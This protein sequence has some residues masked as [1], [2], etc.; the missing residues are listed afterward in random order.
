MSS[1]IT[2]LAPGATVTLELTGISCAL[3]FVLSV[4]L[5]IGTNSRVRAVG[6]ACRRYV[7]VFRSVPLLAIL[8]LLFFGLPTVSP[9]LA[10]SALWCSVIGIAVSEAAF[11]AEIYAGAIRSVSRAQWD[12]AASIGLSR[13]QAYWRVVLP[14]AAVPAAAPTINMLI[15]V[16]K[17]TSVASLIT[18]N[19]LTLRADSL[20]NINARPLATYLVL[21]GFYVVV[22]VPLG[23]AGRLVERGLMARL[24]GGA[25]LQ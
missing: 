11:T 16:I 20:I 8:Y 21:L 18:V 19:E 13:R 22:T 24:G 15:W 1:I 2:A 17:D 3:V 25:V 23:Y 4:A 12:A 9:A 5:A 7:D 14:Q 6:I 10:L